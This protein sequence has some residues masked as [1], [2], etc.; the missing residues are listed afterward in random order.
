MNPI[1]PHKG[2]CDPHIH[3]FNDKAY[4][5]ATHDNP[6]YDNFNMTD[7]QI[8]MSDN[9]VDWTLEGVEKPEDYYCG[10]ID[11]CW[12][13]DAAYRNGKYYWYFSVGSDEIGV[14]VSE[15]PHGPFQ[16]ALGKPLVSIDTQPKGIS[17]WDPC[18]FIDDDNTPYLIC[19]ACLP[20][21]FEDIFPPSDSY[22]IAKLN[23]D[24]V[25]LAEPLKNIVYINNT[26]PED[27]PT[28]HK[29]NGIYYLSHS[30][31]YAISDNVYGPYTYKGYIDAGADHGCY[32]SWHN[33]TYSATSGPEGSNEYFR[34]SLLTY[35][36][37]RDNGEIA[38]DKRI[39]DCG[40]GQYDA[41]WNIIEAEWY[42]AS[43]RVSKKESPNGGFE[44]KG[45]G[46]GGYLYFPNVY[47][48]EA[49]AAMEFYAASDNHAVIEIRQDRPDGEL[50]GSCSVSDTGD[51]YTQVGC[52]LSNTAGTKQIYLVFR[53]AESLRLDW[54]TFNTK[55]ESMYKTYPAAYGDLA[56]IRRRCGAVV[57]QRTYDP[58]ASNGRIV[59]FMDVE[60]ASVTITGVDGGDGGQAGLLIRYCSEIESRY[61]LFINGKSYGPLFFPSTGGRDMRYDGT[62]MPVMNLSQGKQNEIRIIRID[63]AASFDAFTVCENTEE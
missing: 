28:I 14:G 51:K 1:I 19:G 63:G 16:D 20:L 50:L 8:W 41:N 40:V 58:N 3:I 34:C 25:S 37:Y 45:I 54:F 59:N 35:C 53:D 55:P 39:L 61:E 27:K 11:Q 47:H 6:G 29:H 49:N 17:K 46:D 22:M 21:G 32:F 56:P 48:V 57:P 26:C 33:Q 60:G 43:S 36:H 42:F 23:D 24:M 30:M 38:V 2:V 44:I 52:T 10:P 12:A 13:T 15:S 31:Y 7:W 4:M 62:V 9:L 18:V 5:Y